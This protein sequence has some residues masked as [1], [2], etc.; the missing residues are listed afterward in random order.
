MLQHLQSSGQ[1]CANTLMAV[2]FVPPSHFQ[3]SF[4]LLIINHLKSVMQGGLVV[5]HSFFTQS[6]SVVLM[7]FA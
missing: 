1:L 7:V 6:F 5:F 4:T 3:L 2:E